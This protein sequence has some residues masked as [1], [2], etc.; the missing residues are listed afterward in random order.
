MQLLQRIFTSTQPGMRLLRRL[1]FCSLSLLGLLNLL[2]AMRTFTPE[3]IVRKDV[4]QEYLM[5][6]AVLAGL[7]PYA[8][9]H[10][11]ADL[12]MGPL[13]EAIFHHPSPHPPPVILLS[14]LLAP[15]SFRDAA[16]LWL[17]LELLCLGL[18]LKGLQ[19][20][21]QPSL[22]G[23]MVLSA[24]PALVA[25]QAVEHELLLGQLMTLQL[26]ALVWSWQFVRSNCTLA[27]GVLLGAALATKLI[28]WPLVLLL[29]LRRQWRAAGAACATFAA[30]NLA[31]ALL[32]GWQSVVG[33]YLQTGPQVAALYRAFIANFSL[34]SLSW[35]FFDGTGSPAY[36]AQTAPP[37][38]GQ[39]QLAASLAP[40][41]PVAAVLIGLWAV[42]RMVAFDHCFGMLIAISILV[43]PIAWN[44][45]LLLCLLPLAILAQ[46]LW[47][48]GLPA[49]ETAATLLVAGL[50]ALPHT[51][52]SEL[53][54]LFSAEQGAAVYT[55]V[56]PFAASL[57]SLAPALGLV[58]LSLLLFRADQI[59]GENGTL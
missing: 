43:A 8:P 47:Q 29:A 52:L 28:A 6:Q 44:H 32:I 7:D 59:H 49:R 40:L 41:V 1:L 36:S 45:Y 19:R 27:G 21:L 3:L 55:G 51:W 37:L 16:L 10:R 17:V 31:A 11:L 42:R 22:P 56:V 38:W 50:F 57:L 25:W 48:L 53:I 35:R 5:A 15:F 23:W 33:Y 12:L 9:L 26:A 24:V 13:P 46:R 18:A 2:L 39:P 30:A 4:I 34:W 20:S 54:G 14:L 58:G